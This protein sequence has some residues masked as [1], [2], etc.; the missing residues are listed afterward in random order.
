MSARNRARRWSVV[1]C[2]DGTPD[3]IHGPY[4]TANKASAEA[5][6]LIA[7]LERHNPATNGPADWR[8]L[9]LP[10][11]GGPIAVNEYRD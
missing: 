9:L 2:W 7:V 6:R 3:I 8:V 1:V 5:Q 4:R 11:E 10:V